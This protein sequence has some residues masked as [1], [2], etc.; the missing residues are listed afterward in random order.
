MIFNSTPFR[1]V[2]TGALLGTLLAV[3]GCKPEPTATIGDPFDNFQGMLGQWQLSGFLQLDDQSPLFEQRDLTQFYT[4]DGIVPM[5]LS[6]EESGSYSVAIEKGLNYFGA[7]GIWDLD[8]KERP[9]AILFYPT[10]DM[11]NTTD[12]LSYA[13]GRV[14]RPHDLNL[15]V[16][17][18]RNCDG[19]DIVTYTF[20][21]DRIQ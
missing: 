4:G 20:R 12:T 21:F 5:T 15:D 19:T 9:T 17:L 1:I 8:D 2:A 18:T 16:E 10:D 11:G 13:L 7:Q 6:L 14:V 3:E